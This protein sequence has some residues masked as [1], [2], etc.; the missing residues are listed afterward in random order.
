MRLSAEA[1]L[2]LL[3]AALYLYDSLLLLSSNEAVLLRGWGRR[4][5]AGFGANQWKLGGKEPYLPNPFA[6]QHPLFRLAWT[7]EGEAKEAAA[8]AAPL[9]APAWIDWLGTTV[10]TSAICIFVLL[11][12]GLFSSVGTAFTVSA[13]AG[14]YLSILASLGMVFRRRGELG[15][16]DWQFAGMA[17][18]CLVCPP[19][20]VNLVRKVCTRVVV[21]EPFTQAAQRTVRPEDMLEVNA[22]CLLRIEEQI[23]FE[24][25]DTPRMQAL[26]ATRARLTP[27]AEQ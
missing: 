14:L 1:S 12:L 24:V 7:F 11:P 15:L 5:S 10:V 20:A 18:Q 16:S 19:F 8:G 21:D 25:P 26:Q 6:P 13:V 3:A 2:M 27:T 22:Q 4:W 17:F 23:D 9:Q